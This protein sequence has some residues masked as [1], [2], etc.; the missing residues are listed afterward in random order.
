[1]MFKPF[2]VDAGFPPHQ[3]GLWVG[4]HGLVASIAGSLAGGLLSHRIPLLAA[5]G[6]T[7]A[8]RTVAMAGE[9][10]SPRRGRPP[11]MPSSRSPWP[12]T[13]SAAPSRP[14]CSLS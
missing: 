2:L 5:V 6:V 11:R 14:R 12:S 9:W 8:L 1:M 3:I 4:T 7:S 10:Y 13:S